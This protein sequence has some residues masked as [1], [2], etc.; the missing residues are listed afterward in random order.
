M[1]S[2]A[3]VVCK[4]DSDRASRLS[5]LLNT[6]HDFRTLGLTESC[7]IVSVGV[8][9]FWDESCQAFEYLENPE[10]GHMIF[11]LETSWKI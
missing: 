11:D 7:E 9:Q 6:R 3:F 4:D 10:T 5:Q 1:K 2:K 8:H